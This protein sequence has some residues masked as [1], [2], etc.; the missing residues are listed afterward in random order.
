MN[1]K[2]EAL[3]IESILTNDKYLVPIYQRNY[4]WEKNKYQ[5]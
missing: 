1:K 4:E 3:T 2:E 5:S